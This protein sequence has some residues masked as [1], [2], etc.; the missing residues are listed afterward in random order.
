MPYWGRFRDGFLRRRSADGGCALYPNPNLVP[1]AEYF[2]GNAVW[3]SPPPFKSDLAVYHFTV[4]VSE[5]LIGKDHGR[6][7]SA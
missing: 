3:S 5:I 2:Q 4:P 6:V 7:P 1:V